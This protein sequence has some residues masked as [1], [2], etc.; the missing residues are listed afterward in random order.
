MSGPSKG[1]TLIELMIVVVIVGLLSAIAIPF[2]H[3]QAMK[4]QVSRAVSELGAYRSAFEASVSEGGGVS[5]ERLGYAPSD[6]TNGDSSTAIALLNADGSGHLQVTLGGSVNGSLAGV[7]IRYERSADGQW[8]CA[9]DKAAANQWSDYYA[10]PGC[11]V[12]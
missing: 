1:F 5:N 9:I 10:P 4:S 6:I 8:S 11:V 7:V 12:L 2:Y 3:G